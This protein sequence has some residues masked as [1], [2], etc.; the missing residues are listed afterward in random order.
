[1]Q[2]GEGTRGGAKCKADFRRNDNLADA[3]VTP[4]PG[5][6]AFPLRGRPVLQ[7]PACGR[8][9]GGGI[10]ADGWLTTGDLGKIDEKGRL[11]VTGRADDMLISGGHNIH[12]LTVESCL[13]GCPGIRDVAI[14]GLPDPVWGDRIV[15]FVVGDAT[16]EGI[17]AWCRTRL[18]QAAL[19]RHIIRLTSLPRN[20]AGKLERTVL[21]QL[22]K[23]SRA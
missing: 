8:S 13:A 14:A 17:Q 6:A 2:R 9:T 18:P 16:P 20:A 23:N 15:A 10:A 21:R 19:P 5:S 22:A 1:M 3:A 4:R 11:T 12:P 7:Y